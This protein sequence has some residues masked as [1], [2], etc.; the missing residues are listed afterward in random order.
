MDRIVFFLVSAALCA[1]LYPVSDAKYR[2][3]AAGVAVV[4]LVLALLA[5]LDL[6]SRRREAR[7]RAERAD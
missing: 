2:W 7:R 6:L 1:A 3:V 5:G 4:Y